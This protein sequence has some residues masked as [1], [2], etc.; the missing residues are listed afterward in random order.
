MREKDIRNLER[1]IDL[2][3]KSIK[4]KN[5]TPMESKIGVLLNLLKDIDNVSYHEKLNNYK[6]TLKNLKK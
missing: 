1:K 6:Y 2:K 4:E 3:I 5:I